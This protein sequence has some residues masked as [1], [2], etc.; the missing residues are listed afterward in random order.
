MFF[1]FFKMFFCY[2]LLLLFG[3]GGGGGRK[4]WIIAVA[5]LQ[6][7]ATYIDDS[8]TVQMYN[9]SRNIYSS[10][11]PARQCGQILQAVGIYS[12]ESEADTD[13]I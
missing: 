6:L 11:A 4:P 12:T 3:G 2:L 5:Q 7:A 10:K 13:S 9:Y 8:H 1:H